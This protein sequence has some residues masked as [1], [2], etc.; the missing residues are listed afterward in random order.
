MCHARRIRHAYACRRLRGL[1]ASPRE[2]T[3]AV[4]PCV[5]RVFIFALRH[6]GMLIRKDSVDPAT[7]YKVRVQG[8][9]LFSTIC[10]APK[11]AMPCCVTACMVCS[12]FSLAQRSNPSIRANL[13]AASHT[14]ACFGAC[15]ILGVQGMHVCLCLLEGPRERTFALAPCV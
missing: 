10:R 15:A 4:T 5:Q 12:M 2:L 7:R 8:A 14:C 13:S 9:R 11:Y 1:V 6:K 3:S